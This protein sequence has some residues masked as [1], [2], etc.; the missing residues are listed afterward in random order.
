MRKKGI[1]DA[2]V[3]PMMSLYKGANKKIKVDSDLSEEFEAKVGM[4]QG[5]MLYFFVLQ[6]R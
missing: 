6:L 2:S 1:L 4:H 5:F 3:R